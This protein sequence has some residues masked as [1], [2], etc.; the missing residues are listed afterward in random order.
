VIIA[1]TSERLLIGEFKLIKKLFSNGLDLLHI[2]KHQLDN[3]VMREYIKTIPKKNRKQLVLHSHRYLA[4][5]LGIQRLHFSEAD[6]GSK[7]HLGFKNKYILSTSTHSIDSF[8]GLSNSWAYAFLSP[9][10]PSISKPGYG[11]PNAILHQLKNKNNPHV[12]LIGLGGINE[13][14]Y[15]Q[16][17]DEGAH[18]GALLGSIWLN[19]HPLKTLLTC[20]KIDRLY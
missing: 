17:K 12:H 19:K 11:Y 18:G 5:E 10:F 14:N 16:L 6:R 1:I 7:K 20:K 3:Q 2:R 15:R 13:Y 8:N 9:I 4:E